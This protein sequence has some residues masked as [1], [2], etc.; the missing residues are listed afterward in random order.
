MTR[1]GQSFVP[2]V[3]MGLGACI[4]LESGIFSL[5]GLATTELSLL[6]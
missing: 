5:V 1:Y 3:L 4:L 6:W 2:F